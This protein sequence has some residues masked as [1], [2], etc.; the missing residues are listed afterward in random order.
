MKFNINDDT[1]VIY[2]LLGSIVVGMVVM[3]MMM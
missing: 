1:F 2:L 3:S